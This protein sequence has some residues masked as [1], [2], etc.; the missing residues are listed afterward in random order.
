MQNICSAKEIARGFDI[1]PKQITEISNGVNSKVYKIDDGE[2]AIVLKVYN[3]RE[4]K[5]SRLSREYK[6]LLFCNSNEIKAPK[7]IGKDEKSNAILTKYLEGE[8]IKNFNTIMLS[9]MAKTIALSTNKMTKNKGMEA[10]ERCL[11]IEDHIYALRRRIDR[12]NIWLKTKENMEEYGEIKPTIGKWIDQ[13]LRACDLTDERNRKNIDS[14]DEKLIFSQSDV[15]KHNLIGICNEVYMVDLEYAGSDG[16]SKHIIDW[17]LQ[18]DHGMT[19]NELVVYIDELRKFGI[20]SK[21]TSEILLEIVEINT[22]KWVFIIMNQA[23]A[24]KAVY[25]IEKAR[26]YL[27]HRE[28]AMDKLHQAMLKSKG[29][30]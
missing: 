17:Y 4:A 20:W 8:K 10:K 30:M 1:E 12:W 13:A 21:R 18:P 23:L 5:R 25:A 3:E 7:L 14:K 26:R 9:D 6:N 19:L 15:G 22:Y 2:K 16:L 27:K 24:G 28:S 29:L 11:S